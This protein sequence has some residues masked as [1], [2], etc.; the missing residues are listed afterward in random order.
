FYKRKK[1]VSDLKKIVV[2]ADETGGSFMERFNN[3]LRD[4]P[5][6]HLT[7][8]EIQNLLLRRLPRELQLHVSRE[9]RNEGRYPGGVYTT[10]QMGSEVEKAIDFFHDCDQDISGEEF[11]EETVVES[12]EK[13]KTVSKIEKLPVTTILKEKNEKVKTEVVDPMEALIRSFG[14]MQVK[15]AQQQQQQFENMMKVFQTM[16]PAVNPGQSSARQNN[17]R[18][19]QM[20]CHWCDRDHPRH[21]CN[22]FNDLVKAGLLSIGEDMRIYLTDSS[23]APVGYPIRFNIGSG[24]MKSIVTFDKARYDIFESRRVSNQFSGSCLETFIA[25]NSQEA[26]LSKRILTKSSPVESNKS[27]IT[28]DYGMWNHDEKFGGR[29]SEI[30]HVRGDFENDVFSFPS[31]MK[32]RKR[33]DET[34]VPL[35]KDTHIAKPKHNDRRK[36]KMPVTFNPVGI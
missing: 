1:T 10:E 31:E 21:K 22:E 4:I 33:N 13:L 8:K 23:G 9:L 3:V 7:G 25:G 26:K 11:D 36:G 16:V 17:F 32:L 18:S 5:T 20:L 28:K 30:N 27:D 6:D 15:A 12:H 24:G 34:K 2:N 14:E 35:V 19:G 29:T